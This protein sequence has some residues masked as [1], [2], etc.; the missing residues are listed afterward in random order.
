MLSCL[1]VVLFLLIFLLSCKVF[2]LICS[3]FDGFLIGNC[4]LVFV[5]KWSDFDE[6]GEV[7]RERDEFV[8]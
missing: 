8:V 4:V 3:N 6:E 2:V 5:L 7:E 1:R